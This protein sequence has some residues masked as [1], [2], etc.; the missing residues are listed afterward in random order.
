MNNTIAFIS[1]FLDS[2]KIPVVSITAFPIA[3]TDSLRIKIVINGGSGPA[4]NTF[5]RQ[6]VNEKTLK[7][8]LKE[9]VDQYK[10]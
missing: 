6:D 7:A 9:V 5:A 1:D 8:W 3:E 4:E 2:K 10:K